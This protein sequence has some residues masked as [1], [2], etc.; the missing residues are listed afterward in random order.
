MAVLTDAI[1]IKRK[2][3][4]EFENVPYSCLDKE[5]FQVQIQL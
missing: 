2:S 4:F 5:I 1:N 3:F